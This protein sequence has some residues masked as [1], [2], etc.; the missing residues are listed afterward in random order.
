MPVYR[1]ALNLLSRQAL[2][3]FIDGA[4]LDRHEEKIRKG[5]TTETFRYRLIEAVPLRDGKSLPPRRR[6]TRRWS[7]GSAS[8]SWTPRD[9]SNIPWPG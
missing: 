3:D 9:A 5:K 7:I 2:Y 8:K 4:E 1:S 6:G